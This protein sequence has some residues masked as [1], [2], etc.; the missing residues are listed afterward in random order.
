MKRSSTTVRIA[1]GF[2]WK[3]AEMAKS[4]IVRNQ[5]PNLNFDDSGQRTEALV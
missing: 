2:V 4:K 5:T 1:E 3:V